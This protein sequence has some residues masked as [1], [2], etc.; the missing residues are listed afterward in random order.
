MPLSDILLQL[1]SYPEPT[2]SEIVDQAVRFASM[3]GATITAL[4]LKVDIR[5]PKNR[6][7]DHLMGLSRVAQ[8]EEAKS[9]QACREM[10]EQFTVSARAAGVFGEAL[11][12]SANLYSMGDHVAERARTRD[13]CMVPITDTLFGQQSIA[14]A[15]IFSSGRPTLLFG[16]GKTGLPQGLDKLVLAWDG[17]R[18]A[19]RALSDA[20]PLLQKAKEVRVLTILNEKPLAIAGSGRDA[21]RHLEAHGVNALAEEIDAG[22]KRIGAV[23]DGYLQET[24]PDL[25]VMGA[26]GRTRIREF[27][28]G[29]AT[30]EV[31]REPRSA[32]L[33]SH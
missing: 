7:A 17:S 13:L 30:E 28:L 9:L 29:G 20:L 3:T 19:A 2:G 8:N 14:E 1:D 26:F 25:L 32:L 23:L 4:A 21:V 5:L 22:D 12:G 10:L 27:I 33:L 6:L 18:S 15:V 24:R 16:T 31:L 11:I